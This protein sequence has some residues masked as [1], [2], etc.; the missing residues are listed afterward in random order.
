MNEVTKVLWTLILLSAMRVVAA[1][2]VQEY[3]TK[4]H[5]SND[6]DQASAIIYFEDCVA[7]KGH[8]LP[9]IRRG[10]VESY[11]ERCRWGSASTQAALLLGRLGNKESI[12]LLIKNKLETERE[13]H[14]AD[15]DGFS[16]RRSARSRISCLMALLRLG[17]EQSVGEVRAL[18]QSS[19]VVTRMQGIECVA[20]AGFRNLVPD[21]VPLMAD[22]RDA[23]NIAPSGGFYYVRVCDLALRTIVDV[24]SIKTSFGCHRGMRYS[25]AQIAEVVQGLQVQ[26]NTATT[27]NTAN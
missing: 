14:E 1:D 21:L 20:Y 4:L 16:F 15:P 18:L 10:D 19:N 9:S 8:T 25:D 13:E 23:E 27:T 22:K 7:K 11:F 24:Y 3:M 6:N 26:L 2:E 17:H 12:P 5:S